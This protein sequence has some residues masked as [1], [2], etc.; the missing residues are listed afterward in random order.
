MDIEKHFDLLLKKYNLNYLYKKFIFL[1]ILSTVI[2]ESFHWLLLYFS[3][4][5][6][7]KPELIINYSQFLIFVLGINIPLERYLNNTKSLLIQELKLVNNKYFNERIINMSK[8]ELLDFDLVKYFNVLETFNENI[9]EYILNIKIK[10]DIPI[11]TVTILIIAITKNDSLIIILLGLFYYFVKILNEMKQIDETVLTKKYFQFETIIRNYIINSKNFLINDELNKEY[12]NKNINIFEKTNNEISELNHSLDM[13]VNIIMF[14]F[15]VI[16]I[17]SKIHTL[18]QYDFFYYFLIVYDIE[19]VGD[20][21]NEFYKNKINFNKMQ[22]R[23][24]HLNSFNPEIKTEIKTETNEINRIIISNIVNDM[25]KLIITK[26]II[27]E[28]NDHILVNGESGSGKTTLLYILKGI[29]KPNELTIEPNVDLINSQTYISLP[30][31]K[32]LYNGNLYDI[33]TNFE[34]NPNIQLIK[35]A[36][37]SAK[38]DHILNNNDYVN[39]EKLSGGERIRVLIARIIYIIK[40]RK[41]NILLFDEIDENLNDKLAYEICNNLRDIFKDKIILYIS[42]NEN[43]KKLFT[44][45]IQVKEGLIV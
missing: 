42:H 36:L 17:L 35:Y 19:F 22:E 7:N 40:L 9:Q 11:R 10:H 30:N 14:V 21:I 20:K 8:K 12:L 33:I 26:P 44:K 4:L 31:H 39:I 25:P 24:D 3:E 2:K 34:E 1:S 6:K 38:I 43:V 16:I 29:I 37:K 27:I 18:N 32:S 45:K 13:N 28:P 41:Y 15:I 23:L 5:V